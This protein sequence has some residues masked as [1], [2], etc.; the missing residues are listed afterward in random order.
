VNVAGLPAASPLN[1]REH[2]LLS[3]YLAVNLMYAFNMF[4]PG[5][6]G[7][8][9]NRKPT[10]KSPNGKSPLSVTTSPKK[11]SSSASSLLAEI[12]TEPEVAAHAGS[13]TVNKR[14]MINNILNM[15]FDLK[16]IRATPFFDWLL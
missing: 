14:Q 3:P 2:A 9:E 4:A 5:G 13:A 8:G 10:K 6:I 1:V 11:V 16:R 15:L 7:T 12:A